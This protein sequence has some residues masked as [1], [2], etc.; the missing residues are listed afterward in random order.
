M[1]REVILGLAIFSLGGVLL[2]QDPAPRGNTPT[3]QPSAQGTQP[4]PQPSQPAGQA[5][6]TPRIAPG[7]VIPVELTKTIDAKKVKSGDQVEAK[8]TQDLKT[9]NGD[10][11]VPKDTKVVGRVTGAQARTK[12]QKESQ[13]AI[14]FDHAVMKNGGDV[15]LPMSIQA[16][17]SPNAMNGGNNN[18]NSGSG[19]APPTAPSGG[20][21]APSTGSRTGSSAGSMP[22]EAPSSTRQVP[23]ASDQNTASNTPQI[24]GKTEGVIGISNL[25]LSSSSQNGQGS[26][27]TSEKNNVKLESG[28]LMLLRVNQ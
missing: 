18:A 22:S 21:V 7:S 4:T 14:A 12:D 20:G 25:N 16:V 3:A 2:A 24:T 26:V 15:P 10:V 6:G 27:L 23:P 5:P 11:L 19:S 28:T 17:I 9:N 13:V 8:V 1:K